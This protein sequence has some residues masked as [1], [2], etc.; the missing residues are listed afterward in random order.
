MSS[1]AVFSAFPGATA[2]PRSRNS[3][4]RTVRPRRRDIVAALPDRWR[5]DHARG[6]R[7]QGARIKRGEENMRSSPPCWDTPAA[8]PHQ[9]KFA[10]P[11]LSG[12]RLQHDIAFAGSGTTFHAN[13]FLQA[14]SAPAARLPPLSSL[15]IYHIR[16]AFETFS[17]KTFESVLLTCAVIP[18][19]P[20]SY[21][22]QWRSGPI[23]KLYGQATD[24]LAA[25]DPAAVT[26]PR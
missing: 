6:G 20:L 8:L 25:G 2:P 22:S 1:G 10:S 23:R 13:G 18:K 3:W 24:S 4:K 26:I 15:E 12:G 14:G 5:G 7:R 17:L 11:M 21:T 19:T 9:V 16:R